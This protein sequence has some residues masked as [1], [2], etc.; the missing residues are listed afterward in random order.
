MSL[1]PNGFSINPGRVIGMSLD[2]GFERYLV[3]NTQFE[4]DKASGR[5]YLINALSRNRFKDITREEEIVQKSYTWF[6]QNLVLIHENSINSETGEKIVESYLA[7]INLYNGNVF[8]IPYLY[9][10]FEDG[11]EQ[12]IYGETISTY[13]SILYHLQ[14]VREKDVENLFIRLDG[15]YSNFLEI[16]GEVIN[17]CN[18]LNRTKNP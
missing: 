8:R 10:K 1:I 17:R 4:I 9:L 7:E 12:L 13:I 16:A 5:Q 15:T 14:R 2:I 11:S 3:R 18:T 6:E